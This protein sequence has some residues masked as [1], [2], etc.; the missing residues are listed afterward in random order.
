MQGAENVEQ[1]DDRRVLDRDGFL[2]TMRG[3]ISHIQRYPRDDVYVSQRFRVAVLRRDVNYNDPELVAVL[4]FL[5]Q[6]LAHLD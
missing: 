5:F 6:K 4:R 1:A 3:L 2:W